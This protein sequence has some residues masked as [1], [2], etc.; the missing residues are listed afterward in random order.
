MGLLDRIDLSA[1]LERDE[2]DKRVLK[3]QRRLLQ[4]R[5]TLGGLMDD[6]RPGPGILVVMEGP[7]ASGK[8]GAIKLM[9]NHLDPRHYSVVS[10]GAPS[11]EE[12]DHHFLWRFYKE[13]PGM[14]QMAVFDRS[15]YGRVLVERIE[16]FCT[17]E[18]WKRAYKSIV[19]FEESL[20]LESIILVK[21]YMHI[22]DDEQLARFNRRAGDPLKRWKL[23]EEDWRNREKNR[24]YEKAAEEMFEKTHH[25]LASWD[26]IASEQKRYAR[27]AALETVIKRVE[28]GMARWGI[29][30][31]KPTEAITES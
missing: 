13:L 26:I 3:G 19:D 10:Y 16:G 8:G 5:L 11:R 7:D 20:C 28:E 6:T 31:P 1:R 30:V 24:S 27:V 23:T 14:G 21:L 4:L 18:E 12:K 9:V 15:W 29:P 17:R 2:Y 25:R 22:S